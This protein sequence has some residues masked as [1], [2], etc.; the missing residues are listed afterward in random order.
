[1]KIKDLFNVELTYFDKGVLHC[2][3]CSYKSYFMWG[4]EGDNWDVGEQEFV[5]N[6]WHG[7]HYT[8]KHEFE[9]AVLE[10]AE[11]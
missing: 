6:T 7:H 1:M 2:R 5:L 4:G 10:A 8:M 11:A 3:L 9:L